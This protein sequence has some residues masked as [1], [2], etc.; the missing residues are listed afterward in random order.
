[1][2]RT[3]RKNL[4]SNEKDQLKGLWSQGATISEASK[5]TELKYNT[6]NQLFI[7]FNAGFN[8]HT[9]YMNSKAQNAGY[10]NHNVRYPLVGN[11]EKFENSISCYPS[12][13]LFHE[14]E[15]K[16]AKDF[17][18]TH[19]YEIDPDELIPRLL[20]ELGKAKGGSR[21]VGGIQK[22]YF[23][24]QSLKSIANEQGLKSKWTIG[25]RNKKALKKLREIV[26][27]TEFSE[28]F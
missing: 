20:N 19:F 7:A 16:K 3:K 1:M 21:L 11:Q 13:D 26:Q 27:R 6:V 8:S 25:L 9:D 5:K 10:V 23:Q 18:I 14:I 2:K 28:M 15:R 17:K 4:T 24:S 12:I 22:H